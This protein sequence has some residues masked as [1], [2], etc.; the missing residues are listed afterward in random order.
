MIRL[1]YMIDL[2]PF[3]VSAASGFARVTRRDVEIKSSRMCFRNAPNNRLDHFYGIVIGVYFCNFGGGSDNDVASLPLLSNK[4][5]G[6]PISALSGA[7]VG[8]YWSI[9]IFFELF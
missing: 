7:L 9:L 2:L 4:R 5:H 1:S 6:L 8:P 3:E